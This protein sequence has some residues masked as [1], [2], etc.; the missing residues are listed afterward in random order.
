MGPWNGRRVWW[1]AAEAS[2][3]VLFIGTQFSNLYTTVDTPYELS[4][5]LRQVGEA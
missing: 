4:W 3:R 5:S 2:E 1:K